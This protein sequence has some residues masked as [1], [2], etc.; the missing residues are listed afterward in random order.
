MDLDILVRRARLFDISH[1]NKIEKQSFSM[2][3]SFDSLFTDIFLNNLTAYFVAEV[4]SEIV[5]YGGMWMILGEGH[6]TNIAVKPSYR[7]HGIGK[8]ILKKLLETAIKNGI[9][10]MSLEVRQSN[11]NAIKMY[12]AAGFIKMGVRR[13]YYVLPIEHAYI[14]QKQIENLD[15]ELNEA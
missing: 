15:S 8:A 4:N 10:M 9:E 5:A 7:L 12:E 1:I 11:E 2:P 3:W 13:N 6:I 14:M